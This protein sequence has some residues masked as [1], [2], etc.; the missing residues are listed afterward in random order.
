M[1]IAI[2][3]IVVRYPTGLSTDL[4]VMHLAERPSILARALPRVLIIH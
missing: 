3:P 2:N 1:D 4:L